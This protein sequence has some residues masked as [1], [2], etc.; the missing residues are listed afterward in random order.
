MKMKEEKRSYSLLQNVWYVL[1]HMWKWDKKDVFWLAFAVPGTVFISLLETYMAKTV[2]QLV[3]EHASPWKLVLYVILFSAGILLLYCIDNIASSRSL[4][5]CSAGDDRFLLLYWERYMQVDYEKLE[6]PKFQL[7]AEKAKQGIFDQQTSR[8]MYKTKSLF[9]AVLGI[10]TYAVILFPLSPGMILMMAVISTMGYF[11][12][13]Y[14]HKWERLHRDATWA[15]MWKHMGYNLEKIR[16][17]KAAK[18]IRMFGMNSLLK[19]RF[20]ETL[21]ELM[22]LDR[23]SQFRWKVIDTI[24]ACM[25][26]VRD[27]L[28]YGILIYKVYSGG[29]SAAE[30][31]LYFNALMMFIRWLLQ[32]YD[33]VDMAR[34]QSYKFCDFRDFMEDADLCTE[35]GNLPIPEDTCE[36]R[37][38]NVEYVYPES[39]VPAL[40]HTDFT[41]AKGEKIAIVGPNGA[42]KTTLVKLLCGLY[43]PTSGR[44][45]V[46][47]REIGEYDKRA[48]YGL[49]SS[50][51]QDIAF[52]PKSIAEN[53]ALCSKEKTEEEKLQ[54]TI[55]FS[56]LEEKL[57]KLPKGK[58]TLLVKEVEEE[59]I[60]LSGGEM[61]KLAL[62][63]ALYKD[64]KIL[65]LDEPTAALD[66]IA[67]SDIYQKYN[68]LSQGKTAIFISHRLASTK[69]CDRIFYI[70]KGQI[71]EM[72]THEELMKRG[73][74]YAEMFHVQSQYYKEV[75]ESREGGA[76]DEEYTME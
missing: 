49:F 33:G 50:V 66:P 29:M 65:V 67:E 62:A 1:K 61:Q 72:G 26:M 19:G 46:D 9:A 51:F 68:E 70:E 57:K 30:F 10:I 54:R 2:V 59:A 38:E 5:G 41:I 28:A 73:G 48:Y 3:T 32:F 4:T 45:L 58:E 35:G 42:G 34:F 27:F 7:L 15:P 69:F 40:S 39:E 43:W 60:A 75:E 22:R 23:H 31:V 14:N 37:F 36:I 53:I 25:T 56:G 12:Y 71:A 55:H 21:N 18:D 44:I 64:G 17:S 47:G 20:E 16:D 13:G 52:L 24:F 6:N 63:R 74:K 11:I 76:E 8:M